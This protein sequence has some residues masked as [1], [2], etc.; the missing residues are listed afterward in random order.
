MSANIVVPQLGESVVEARIVRWLK[1][2]GERVQVGEPLVELE[3]DKI[4]LEV[5]AD[6]SGVLLEVKRGEGED[7][8]VGDVLGVIGDGDAT[9]ATSAQAA[10]P[11][12]PAQQPQ[13]SVSPATP[14]AAPADTANASRERATPTARKMAKNHAVDLNAVTGTGDAGRVT[15]RDVADALVKSDQP[16]PTPPPSGAPAEARPSPQAPPS[17]S[18]TPAPSDGERRIE[19][20]RMSKRRATIAR[21]LVEA[22]H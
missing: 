4:D 17:R 19:R 13:S 11:R 16:A 15:K 18:P 1:Q 6:Q 5:P 21:N 9:A 8:L 20:V 14:P 3:T 22:Q 7:V 10:P 2:P 12:A